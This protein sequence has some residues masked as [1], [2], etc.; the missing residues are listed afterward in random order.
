[1]KWL[2]WPL[3]TKR[4]HIEA[5]LARLEADISRMLERLKG[6]EQGRG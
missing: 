6:D 5:L 3:A 4:R 2:R 1:M